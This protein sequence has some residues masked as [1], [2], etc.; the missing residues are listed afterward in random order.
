M[1]LNTE[2]MLVSTYS[3]KETV[4]DESMWGRLG[5]PFLLELY[6]AG[7]VLADPANLACECFLS[8]SD[9]FQ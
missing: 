4:S 2:K 7:C 3:V 5:P 6:S 1:M 8:A 9:L